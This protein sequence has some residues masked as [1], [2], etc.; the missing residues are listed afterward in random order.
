VILKK[1]SASRFWKDC[2]KYNVTVSQYLGELCRYLLNQPPSPEDKQHKVRLMYGNGVRPEIWEE[3]LR[4]FNN[5]TICELYG[6]TEG[7]ASLVN[8]EGKVG[9]I[10]VVPRI[11]SL[12]LKSTIIK[13]DPVTGDPIRKENGLAI[14]CK[15]NEPG[16]AVSLIVEGDPIRQFD[17][18]TDPKATE[19]KI[20][21]DIFKKGDCA[22]RSGD[23]LVMDEYG[24]F[25]FKDRTGDTFR[26]KG[27]NVSTTEVEF[28]LSKYSDH[29]D[30]VVYGVQIPGTDGRAGMASIADPEDSLNLETLASGI[31]KEL[32]AYARPIFI[33]VI[34]Q[35]TQTGTY[36]LQKMDLLKDE[37]NIHKI[38]DK[39]YFYQGGKYVPLTAELYEKINSGKMRI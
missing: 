26:W 12:F 37:Y 24:Y 29:K 7:N 35:I 21:R 27:E 13:V 28:T 31:A 38:Q 2:I 11:A 23:I 39:I 14:R 18:Y 32:P 5:P 9:A 20:I 25:Y 36:K 33:R 4:R 34:P 8:F 22:F 15:P 3:F 19:K 6:A 16:E 17:G 30:V 10:G 1:F